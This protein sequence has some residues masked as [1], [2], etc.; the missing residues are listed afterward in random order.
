ML[1]F[2][3]LAAAYPLW[4]PRAA[5]QRTRTA[6]RALL[7]SSSEADRKSGAWSVI[8]NPDPF[9]VADLEA[10][11]FGDEPSPDVREAAA[12][13][14]GHV[15]RAESL[16]ALEQAVVFDPS[17]YVRAAIWLAAARIDPACVPRWIE[18]YGGRKDAWDRLGVAQARLAAGDAS[19][20][21]EL[22]DLAAGGDE[23]QRVVAARALERDVRP[24]LEELGRWPIAWEPRIGE[25]WPARL[26]AEVRV[27]LAQ[28]DVAV[29][30]P[31]SQ[32][33]R[34][35][36]EPLR[37]ELGRITKARGVLAAWL[38]GGHAQ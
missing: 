37:R 34:R 11:V 18:S 21:G 15:R 26:L 35:A 1:I 6:I 24:L 13:A 38:S 22:L 25:P 14:L 32:A 4:S 10:M 30:L 31:R 29:A 20:I 7:R 8:D 17:G 36:S 9:L 16:A 27:R 3:A 2:A 23:G 19:G 5:A 12:Y 28:F 33:A